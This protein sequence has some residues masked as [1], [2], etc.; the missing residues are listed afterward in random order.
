MRPHR[1][2]RVF[3]KV[4]TFVLLGVVVLVG[5]A[6]AALHTSWGKDQVRARAE[7]AI[8]GMLAGHLSI[9]IV[10]GSFFDHLVLR[11]VALLDAS[12]REA[13]RADAVSVDFDL[14]S[15]FSKLVL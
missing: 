10:E 7:T 4:I 13:F 6:L 9:G 12:G 1:L 3:L 8:N 15:L 14:F 2:A 11:D 5:A